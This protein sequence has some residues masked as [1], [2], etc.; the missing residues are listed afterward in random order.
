MGFGG[1]IAL[2][3]DMQRDLVEQRGWIS[4]EDYLEGLALAQLSPGPL[5]A[6]LAMYLGWVRGGRLGAALV[7]VA[8]VL[9]SLSMVMLLAVFYARFGTLGWMRGAFYGVGAAVVAIIARSAV[10]LARM[11][12]ARDALL[13]S[14]FGLT[15]VVTAVSES[16]LVLLFVAC[17]IVNMLLKAPPGALTRGGLHLVPAWLPAC[18]LGA[19]SWSTLAQVA[20]VF[21]KSGAFV[22]GS[23][24]AIVPFLYQGV[25]QEHHWL[26]EQQFRDAVAVAMITPGPV[27]ITG[28]FIG[29][30]AAGAPGAL[31][32]VLGTF[33]PPFLVVALAARTVRKA[34]QKAPLATFLA[35]LTASA[36][37]AIAGATVILGRKAIFDVP[38]VLIA[39]VASVA[40]LSP[41]RV[42]EP[43]LIAVAGAVGFLLKRNV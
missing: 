15:A 36:T 2:A 26:D 33:V 25:V 31:V 43:V 35:G 40:L 42:P 1:P 34:A 28:A 38:T 32:A 8:F 7:G 10:K 23:G 4:K 9:P 14:V 11:T 22:F 24:L 6:Q 18:V 37:G 13:W 20:W 12:L 19:A 29:Y 41:K 27:V 21:T 16:E 30:L 39:L 5:A 17:G 3:G